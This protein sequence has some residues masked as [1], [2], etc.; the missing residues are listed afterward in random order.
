[1]WLVFSRGR[2]FAVCTHSWMLVNDV[3]RISLDALSQWKRMHSLVRLI[4]LM[5]LYTRS[6]SALS[7][8]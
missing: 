6:A 2:F 4:L 5:Y 8:L 7:V 3:R 1:M